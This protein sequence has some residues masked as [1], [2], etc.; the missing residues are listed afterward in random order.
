M[1]L[2]GTLGVDS[3]VAVFHC[4]PPVEPRRSPYADAAPRDPTAAGHR[5]GGRYD[6][7]RVDLCPA[8]GDHRQ[9]TVAVVAAVRALRDADP[10]RFERLLERM[11]AATRELHGRLEGSGTPAEGRA[12]E[13]L[14]EPMREFEACLEQAG[15]VP[16]WL[17]A[18]VREVESHGGA[19]KISGAGALSGA[20]AGSFLVYHPDPGVIDGWA[21][22]DR[23]DRLDVRL[24]AEGVRVED[25]L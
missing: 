20:G 23:L 18:I 24:G 15:V 8:V 16:P 1:R 25:S 7:R 4:P 19:A 12:D 3:V 17:R 22:L 13:S 2:Q 14:V 21:F 9:G 10:G 5:H 6:H 11:E